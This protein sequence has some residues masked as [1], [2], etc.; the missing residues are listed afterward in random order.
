MVAEH[1]IN[2]ES[3]ENH[4]VESESQ[5]M[6]TVMASYI[7]GRNQGFTENMI[8]EIATVVS[9]LA[10]NIVKYTP[11]GMIELAVVKRGEVSGIQV[12]AADRGPGIK[13]IDEAMQEHFTTGNSLGMGLPGVKRMAD[14]FEIESELGVGTVVTVT[15][16]R[17]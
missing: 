17:L 2:I 8:S 13:D 15:K 3:K 11:G 5:A 10:M 12:V 1:A 16:W 4:C 9:E 7:L 6:S 14:Q